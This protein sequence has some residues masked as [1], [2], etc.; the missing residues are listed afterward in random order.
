[1]SVKDSPGDPEILDGMKKAWNNFHA[2]PDG[3]KPQVYS[4]SETERDFIRRA[5][6][7]YHQRRASK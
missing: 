7:I 6:T 4:F 5:C 3:Q 1:M 2:L